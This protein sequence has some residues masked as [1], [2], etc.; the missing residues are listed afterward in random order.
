MT[1]GCE[2]SGPLSFIFGKVNS[3]SFFRSKPI[4]LD[5]DHHSHITKIRVAQRNKHVCRRGRTEIWQ[6]WAS[7]D[8]RS[9]FLLWAKVYPARVVLVTDE[10]TNAK[11]WADELQ[12]R[13]LRCNLCVYQSYSSGVEERLR[14]TDL[15]FSLRFTQIV[16]LPYFC[17]L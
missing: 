2:N 8:S 1:K 14:R 11:H 17:I 10:L 16:F 7:S 6:R 4:L 13:V 3:L 9:V 12:R 15:L 5:S